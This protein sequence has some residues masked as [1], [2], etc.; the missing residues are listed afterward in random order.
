MAIKLKQYRVKAGLT[1]AQLAKAVGVSQPNYQR[2]ESGAAPVPE[3]KL[4]KLAKSLHVSLDI[5][6][7][8]H[9]PI[10][11]GFYDKSAGEDLNYYGEVAIHFRDGG[12]PLLLSISDGAFSRLHRDLQIG[13]AFVTVESLANQTVI[14]RTQAMADLYFSSEAYDDYGPEHDDYE[15]HVYLQMPDARDWEI[16]EAI[17]CDDMGLEDF[18]PEDVQRV[19]SQIMITDEQ[20]DQLVAEGAIK[21]EDLEAEKAKNQEETD[22]ICALATQVTYQTS[23]GKRRSMSVE[24]PEELFNAFEPLLEDLGDTLDNELIRLSGDGWHRIAFINMQAIDYVML[25]THSLHQGRTEM[26]AKLLDELG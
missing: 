9:L 7:N 10:K 12:K 4:R 24:S 16:V 11:A 5:L 14:I 23:T 13:P 22:Q 15:D 3:D 6:R 8:T 20:Y 19:R 2:W 21:P 1:Q 25:P 18:S 17:A 26:G